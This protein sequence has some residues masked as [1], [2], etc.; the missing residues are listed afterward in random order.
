MSCCNNCGC[1]STP[2][3]N[4]S[5]NDVAPLDYVQ[6]VDANGCPK[7]QSVTTLIPVVHPAATLTNNAAAFSWNSATQTG[8]IPQAGKLVANADGSYTYTAGDGSAPVIIPKDCCPTMTLAGNTITFTN[9]DGTIISYPIHPSATLTNNAAPFAWNSA[10]QTGNI[11]Q[12]GRLV[13]NANGSYTYTAG[14]GSAPVIIPADCCPTMTLAGNT[15]TFT[16]GDGTVVT[17]QIHPAA[18]LTNNAAPFAWNSATQTGNIPQSPSLALTATGFTFTPGNGSAPVSYVAPADSDTYVSAFSIAGN[19]ATIT[20]NDGVIL[21]AT[22]PTTIDINVQSFTLSGSNLVLTETDG[23]V[24]TVAIPTETPITGVD[25]TTV[26][27]SIG[28]GA[29]QHAIKADVIVSAAAD[30]LLSVTPSGL[31]ATFTE[32]PITPI[33]SNT[34]DISIG[35]GA[36]QHAIKADVIVS[37]ATDNQLVAAPSGLYVPLVP[38]VG[39][40]S[41]T[42]D[43]S[44]GGGVTQHAIK[45]DVIVSA[46]TDNFLVAAPSGLY[47][48]ADAS[49][50]NVVTALDGILVPATTV[51]DALQQIDNWTKNVINPGA[52]VPIATVADAGTQALLN[53]GQF[54]LAETNEII[55]K[56]GSDLVLRLENRKLSAVKRYATAIQ[57]PSGTSTLIPYNVTVDDPFGYLVNGVFTAPIDGTYFASASVMLSPVGL[58]VCTYYGWNLWIRKNGA[59]YELTDYRTNIATGAGVDI[60]FATTSRS[61]VLTG[62]TTLR[63][64]AGDTIDFVVNPFTGAQLYAVNSSGFANTMSVIY[65]QS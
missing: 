34:V 38:I 3:K 30:N 31:Y 39:V 52:T 9:G 51:E 60:S 36:T 45:A 13:A 47:A 53:A 65:V 37:P 28:G 43:I 25:S 24:H 49:D 19:V 4:I 35:G 23:T 55:P 8:N 29:A 18:T 7:Y 6:G 46:A 54:Q 1:N 42:V 20:R 21:T 64:N 62:N 14:D 58:Q 2:C 61:F 26:D 56:I 33:D 40:D 27:I 12:A 17:F 63:L 41:N 10:T 57:C 16:N 5:I 50:I 59:L 32:T 22:I 11:P 44:I 15:V 48:H